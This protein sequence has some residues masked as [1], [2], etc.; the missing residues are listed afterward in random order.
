MCLLWEIT[1][2][3]SE[4]QLR[5]YHALKHAADQMCRNLY[6]QKL[7]EHKKRSKKPLPFSPTT[8]PEVDMLIKAMSDVLSRKLD[9]ESAMA[10]VHEYDVMKQR[11]MEV[12]L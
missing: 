3:Y 4:E 1:M 8:S 2:N 5:T 7:A 9:C 10:L 6:Q 11:F 12:T